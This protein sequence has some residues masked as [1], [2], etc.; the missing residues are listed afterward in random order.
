MTMVAKLLKFMRNINYT[1]NDITIQ[2]SNLFLSDIQ[3]CSGKFLVLKLSNFTRLNGSIA[4]MND[5][6]SSVTF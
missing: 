1:Y 5:T 2:T 6:V 3:I 4:S